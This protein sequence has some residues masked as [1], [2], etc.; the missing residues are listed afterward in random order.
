M[1]TFTREKLAHPQNRR[2]NFQQQHLTAEN[3]KSAEISGRWLPAKMI[4][5]FAFFAFSAVNYFLCR[6]AS[7]RLCVKT[8]AVQ[9]RFLLGPAGSG[10]TFRCLAEIRA[11]LHAA[12]DGPPLILL[13][14]KQAT[15]QLERQLLEDG[16]I[17]GFTRLQILSFDRLAQ[18][19][20]EKLNVAPPKLLSAEGRLMVLRALLQRHADELKLFRGSARRAGFAQEL[21]AL[22]AELQQ[23]QFTPAKL[24]ALAEENK[25]RRELR[26][27]LHDLALL[28]EKYAAWLRDHELQDA[29]NLLDFAT[30]ALRQKTLNS[31][32]STLNFSGL[33][34]DGFAEMTPQELALLA[35]VIPL[36]DRATIAFCLETEPTPTESWLS[37]WS[38]IGKT[39]QQCR[40]QIKNLPGC[41]VKTEIIK[42]EPGKNRFAENSAL[43]ELAAGWSLPVQPERRSPDRPDQELAGRETSAPIRLTECANPETEAVFAAREV[44]KFVRAKD[45][46][47]RFRDCAVLVRQLDGYHKPLARIFRRYGI[48]FFLDRRE[49]VA[50]H[51]LAEL[52]RSALRTVAFDWQNDDW[53]AALKAGFSP[54]VETETDR[55]E[56]TALE[57]GWR[58]KKWREPLPDEHCERLRKII[59]PPFENLYAQFTKINFKP[60]GAQ[61]ADILRELW[62]DLKVEQTLERWTLDAEP[63]PIADRQ[64][65]THSTVWEQMNSWLEN[66]ALAFPREPLPLRDWLPILDAGLANLTVGVIPPALDEVLVGA[67]D[68]ARNPSLKF[69]LLLGVN[70]SVFPATPAAPVI[71]TSS[72][73][74]ELEKQNAALGANLFNQ[75]SR[76]RYLG[77][78][79]CT[80]A[81]EKLTLT[82]SRQTAEGKTLNPSPFIAQLQRMF[83]QLEVEEFSSDSDWRAAQHANELVAPLVEIKNLVG[84]EVT[85]LKSKKGQRLLT[86]SP[87]SI[88]WGSLLELPALKSLMEKLAALR[89]PEEK[90][91]LSEALAKKLYGPV[92]KSSVS[93]LEEFAQCPFKFFV[94]SGLRANERK[95][96]EL[97]ARERG[98]F[99]HDVLKIFHEQLQA[100][101]RRW[102]DLEPLEARDRIGQIAAAQMEHFRDGLF[103]DSAETVFAARSLAAALQDFVG[104]IV[105]WMRGQYEFDPAAAELGFG[106]KD[107]AA[108]AWEIDLGGGHKLA[109]QGRIDRVDLWRD[110]NSDSALA[111]VTDYKSG[112]KK[113]DS[114]LVENGVQLQLLA[115][116]G[117]LRNW[118]A[119]LRP[120]ELVA[121]IFSKRA[122][123]ETG[124]PAIKKIIPAG[125]FYVNLRGEFKSG[126]SRA[127]VLGDAEAKKLA[128]RHTGRFDAGELRKFDRRPDVSKGDQFNFRL[129]KD[130][131]L[132]SNSTEAI[133]GKEFTGLLDQVED[134]LR[135]L[136]GQIF[137]GMAAVDPYRKGTQTPCEYCDYR[138]ACR[139]DEWTHE[140]RG[141]RAKESSS[142]S[143]S[144]S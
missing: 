100:E 78:I 126:G 34:L 41:E 101:G 40:D 23:H 46:G 30:V 20:F 68:R 104:V 29:N 44:L 53:F 99:Q 8:S 45:A 58:G 19:V 106:G 114:L 4:D 21:G 111:V 18:F 120:G 56:N 64:P 123:S 128:Y 122:G 15:F 90:E 71:L 94:R 36:C 82:F 39:F 22:L 105:G 67:I 97:D 72:D 28:S 37:I 89:E 87:T 77:Y 134:Q 55:L 116:L 3:A 137:S 13:A 1:E 88:D 47:N 27:K 66:L 12:P 60:T 10:K 117:A 91:N 62:S 32:L 38:A 108:P 119:G 69:A 124:V 112:G 48:P 11:A 103:R 84:D 125:A 42:C 51:P 80:R 83:P 70:E 50:H 85:S 132:P 133:S 75:I 138:A 98:N 142:S 113:L 52:T 2:N 130:G 107:D 139:I 118:N 33:W 127:E 14:P 135:S 5:V 115:Y 76:E 7:A 63:S 131:S 54:V 93:R 16:E 79:A 81:N 102:R 9:A 17:S 24:R 144:S 73:R 86:S 25:L 95:V 129:N 61:L 57:F 49:S 6:F 140:W 92:L 59:F 110:P 65:A 143:S 35:A 74:D 109:L 121:S 43:A 26:D 96:F 31:Q 141:L 136:G